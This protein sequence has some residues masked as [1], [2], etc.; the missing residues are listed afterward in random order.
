MTKY[1]K[2]NDKKS[3]DT[4]VPKIVKEIQLRIPFIKCEMK[5]HFARKKINFA[6]IEDLMITEVVLDFYLDELANLKRTI[7]TFRLCFYESKNDTN[8]DFYRCFKPLI[9]KYMKCFNQQEKECLKEKLVSFKFTKLNS[10]L[11]FLK[12]IA[13]IKR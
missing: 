3:L 1:R 9:S 12:S 6:D 13:L 2:Q 11:H 8:L 7:N 10:I 5:E 4:S